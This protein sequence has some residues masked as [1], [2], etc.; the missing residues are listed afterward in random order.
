MVEV[1]LMDA[2][3]PT[4]TSDEGEHVRVT[5]LRTKNSRAR[6]KPDKAD[7]AA[8]STTKRQQ[9]AR[10]GSC[11]RLNCSVDVRNFVADVRNFAAGVRNFAAG[12]RNFAADVP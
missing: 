4:V 7:K 11:A 8:H 12:V 1:A 3:L 6:R 10:T 9:T 5:V 2:P